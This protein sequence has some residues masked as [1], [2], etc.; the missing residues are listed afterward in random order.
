MWN[1]TKN[2]FLFEIPPWRKIYKVCKPR[3]KKRYLVL[4]YY[5]QV[6]D[7]EAKEFLPSGPKTCAATALYFIISYRLFF[8]SH[9]ENSSYDLLLF[10]ARRRFALKFE[11][12]FS[13]AISIRPLF[14]EGLFSEKSLVAWKLSNSMV[15]FFCWKWNGHLVNANI[16]KLYHI[17][18]WFG[19]LYRF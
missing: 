3:C 14:F 9:K 17:I 13:S 11:D 8:E 16:T 15:S 7:Q 18:R 6:Q 2:N 19:I 10:S 4:R 5:R 1:F 12:S